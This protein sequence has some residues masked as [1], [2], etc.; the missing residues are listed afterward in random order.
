M[1]NI[2]DR[3]P[4][5]ETFFTKFQSHPASVGES[6]FGHMRFALR[7][8]GKLFQAAGAALVHAVIPPLCETTASRIVTEL[9]D[10]CNHRHAGD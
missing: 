7:F 10:M 5:R 3:P 1:T 4:V 8:A 2:A 6:Y 9:N